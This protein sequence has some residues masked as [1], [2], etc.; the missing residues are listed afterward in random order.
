MEKK[1]IAKKLFGAIGTFFFFASYLPYL[2][3]I[4]SSVGGVQSGLFGGHYIYGFD[5]MFNLL[6][7]FIVIPIVP[8]CFIYQMVFGLIYI[9][10]RKILSIIT[11]IL[12]AG[13]IAGI[14]LVG[15]PVELKKKQQFKE[16]LPV[17]TEYLEEKYGH[18]M[19]SNLNIS[20]SDYE[21][22]DYKVT[23]YVLPEGLYFYTYLGYPNYDDLVPTFLRVNEDYNERFNDYI[24][25]K[26]DLP[27]NVR[28]RTNIESID[29]GDYKHGD[30]TSELYDRTKYRITEM[31]YEAKEL[32]DE[33]VIGI[34]NDA[35][36]NY[37]SQIDI[38]S[39]TDHLILYIKQNGSFAFSVTIYP[40]KNGEPATAFINK[41]YN[42]TISTNLDNTRIVLD[43]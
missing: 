23:T 31:D 4:L 15:V 39:D 29:F 17:I 34:I 8:V 26:Y 9:R 42:H 22:H 10:K 2:Y 6:Q 43:Q 1:N 11:L 14:L 21:S 41:Y 37:F 28:F 13:I 32:N 33:I 12:V 36:S 16:D 35:W 38:P 30:D 3:I 20:L 27:E 5:A 19:A 24:N 7:W 40:D 25:N 18:E